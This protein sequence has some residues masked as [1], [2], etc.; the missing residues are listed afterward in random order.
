MGESG[1]CSNVRLA[2]LVATLSLGTD[3]GLGQPMEHVLRQCLI[4]LRL[5]ERFGFDEAQRRVVYYS[6]LLAWV[7]CFTDAHEQAKWFG[8]DIALKADAYDLS[9]SGL[10]Y[11]LGHI[12]AGR[13]WTERIRLGVTFLG[14]GRRAILSM[15][16][17]HYL[18]ADALAGRLGLGD[19]VRESLKQTFERWDGKQTPLGLKGEEILLPSRLIHLANVVEVF[20]RQHGVEAAVK[21]ASEGSGSEFDPG[22]VEVFCEQ[23]P[24]LLAG[25]DAATS[26]D[27]VLAAEP[28]LQT[29][30]SDEQF[31][32]ALDAVADFVDLKSPYTIGHSR[33]VAD[34]AAVAARDLGLPGGAVVA[35]RRAG[36]VHDFGRLGVSNA[37]WDKRGPL[38]RAEF[39]RV[40]LHP[41]LTERMLAFSPALAPLGAIAVQHHERLDGSGYPR[42][43]SGDAIGLEGRILGAAD[44]YHALTEVRPHRPARAPE[45][46]AAVLR[47]EVAAGRLDGDAVDAVLRAA[48]HRVKRR[49]EWPADLTT[50]EVEVLRL[51]TRGY[52]NREIAEH[53]TITRKTA[54]NHVQHIYEKT[55]ATNRARA[56]LFAMKHGLMSDLE[57][58]GRP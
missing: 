18:A 11:L 6:G 24:H 14:D 54:G 45:E 57:P 9:G 49:R 7:G 53:L 44:T 26:W 35:V 37:I 10:G 4:A 47:A 52:S 40:R 19:E 50:R 32:G 46:A 3:L 33:G 27:V 13:S 36:L 8:D 23:A 12:G 55:G 2:E 15:L 17:N 30:I 20:H 58:L 39:E 38:T 31:E 29:V 42:G 22:V 56:A 5:S 43:L 25:L 41:Y 21:V 34:L 16:E 48:G 28:S 1:R 51:V